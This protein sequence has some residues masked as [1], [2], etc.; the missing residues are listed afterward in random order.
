MIIYRHLK[1]NIIK[2]WNLGFYFDFVEWLIFVWNLCEGEVEN[3]QQCKIRSFL[4]I[5][6]FFSPSWHTGPRPELTPKNRK[7]NY[8][9]PNPSKRTKRSNENEEIGI[10]KHKSQAIKRRI[11]A[12]NYRRC[13]EK[14]NFRWKHIFTDGLHINPRKTKAVSSKDGEGISSGDPMDAPSKA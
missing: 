3:Y 8:E 9:E 2:H 10:L 1:I 11:R 7:R 4:F 5:P 14:S 13:H 12:W 6:L